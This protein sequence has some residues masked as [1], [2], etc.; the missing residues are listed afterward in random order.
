MYQYMPHT[1]NNIPFNF[2]MISP[3]LFSEH[4]NSFANN[5]NVLYKP[6]EYDWVLFNIGQ[7]VLAFVA[8]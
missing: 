2:G 8:E 4:I 1:F 5:F 7:F 6:E 3:K